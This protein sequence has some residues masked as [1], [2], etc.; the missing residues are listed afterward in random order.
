MV[1]SGWT[2]RY[3]RGTHL[4]EFPLN[5]IMII[6]MLLEGLE[7]CHIKWKSMQSKCVHTHTHSQ[8]EMGSQTHTHRTLIW[9]FPGTGA[10]LTLTGEL[11]EQVPHGASVTRPCSQPQR[12]THEV[13]YYAHTLHMRTGLPSHRLC[14]TRVTLKQ[15]PLTDGGSLSQ[16]HFPNCHGAQSAVGKTYSLKKR[17]RCESDL[18][19]LD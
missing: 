2:G 1:F 12:H 9:T 11:A 10:V 6:M 16:R 17:R 14:Q 18:W 7:Q 4:L 13:A 15:R 3:F 8:R 19:E 5:I